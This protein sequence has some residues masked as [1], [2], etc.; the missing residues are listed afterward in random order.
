MRSIL[1]DTYAVLAYTGN[2]QGRSHVAEYLSD[3]NT[4]KSRGVLS[5]LTLTEIITIVGREDLDKAMSIVSYIEESPIDI[6]MPDAA[7]AKIAGNLR[8]KYRNLKLSLADVIIIATAT[9]EQVDLVVTGD[10]EWS[11][12]GEISVK[13]I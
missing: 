3:I 6:I 2:E 11:E 10:D 8:L 13:Q 5:S 12:V 7:I 4:G 9:Q 1:L